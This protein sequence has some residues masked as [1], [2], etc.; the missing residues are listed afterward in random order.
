MAHA[1]GVAEQRGVARGSR[2]GR[3]GPRPSRRALGGVARAGSVVGAIAQAGPLVELGEEVD[4]ARPRRDGE[5]EPEVGQAL[6]DQALGRVDEEDARLEPAGAVD[7]VRLP[8]GVLEVVAGVGLVGDDV[9]EV[10]GPDG[11]SRLRST[12][13]RSPPSYQL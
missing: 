4:V 7:Q 5:R 11:R 1:V 6:A 3:R 8:P 10:V 13:D 2:R 9:D 12:R